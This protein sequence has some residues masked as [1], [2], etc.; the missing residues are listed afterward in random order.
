MDWMDMATSGPGIQ[1]RR[2][3]EPVDFFSG[4]PF[5]REDQAPDHVFYTQ[6]RLVSHVDETARENLAGLY[7]RYL[8]PGTRILDLMSSWQS[9][10]PEG[11]DF[12]RVIG[13]GMNERELSENP[14][15]SDYRV[16]DLNKNPVIPFQDSS[17]DAVICSLSVEYLTRPF[18]VFAEIGRILRPGGQCVITFSNRW[19]PAK[20]IRIWPELHEFE[21]MAVVTDYFLESGRFENLETVS[22]RGYPRPYSDHYFPE[23]KLSDP[24]YMVH[25]TTAF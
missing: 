13:L 7:R 14:A 23:L 21:R 12:E 3:K 20:T 4:H 9:H 18:D 11:L 24:V 1:A 5:D 22:L 15:L 6:D 2:N 19:F 25:G 16:H 8:V 10:L 17:F